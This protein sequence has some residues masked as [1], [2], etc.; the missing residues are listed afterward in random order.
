MYMQQRK[1]ACDVLAFSSCTN[2][3]I[4][5]SFSCDPPTLGTNDAPEQNLC[6]PSQWYCIFMGLAPDICF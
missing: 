6:L 4:H 2:E 5:P 1:L 3:I